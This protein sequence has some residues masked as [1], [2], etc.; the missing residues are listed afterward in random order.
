LVHE[1]GGQ[2]YLDGANLNSMVGRIR[3][4][5]LGVD[6]LH[7]NLH[8]TFSTP[9]GGGGP[10]AGP[11]C[12]KS[13]LAPFL[14]NPRVVQKADASFGLENAEKGINIGTFLGNIP[15]FIRAYA[16]I[17][18]LGEEGLQRASAEAVLNANYLMAK[19]I[20]D[21]D[22][23]CA[24]GELRMHEFV[25]SV[26]G[27]KE[28]TARW[29]TGKVGVGAMDFAK[30]LMDF[31]IHPP[32]VLFPRIK[33][34][35]EET[36]MFEPTQSMRL[37]DLDKV[38]EAMIAIKKEAQE[39]PD[40]VKNAPYETPVTSQTKIARVNVYF[41]AK[42]AILK[43]DDIA[44][45][46]G[47]GE[48]TF[49][50]PQEATGLISYQDP[51]PGWQADKEKCVHIGNTWYRIVEDGKLAV[52]G[53]SE[54]A[55]REG[56][57]L[58]SLEHVNALP[59]VGSIV[60][61]GDE[62]MEF[63]A[64]KTNYGVECP[65]TGKV[66]K[67]NEYVMIEDPSLIK[68][69]PYGKGWLFVVELPSSESSDQPKVLSATVAATGLAVAL[70]IVVTLA[71]Y[72]YFNPAALIQVNEMLVLGGREGIGALAMVPMLGLISTR[73]SKARSFDVERELLF[74]R[75]QIAETN[76]IMGVVAAHNIACQLK[77][78][79]DEK[80][81]A[82]VLWASAPSQHTT[83]DALIRFFKELGIDPTKIICFHMDEYVGLP[84]GAPQSFAKV[85]RE[86]LFTQLGI[87]SKN[88]FYFD[89][90]VGF[91][92]AQKLRNKLANKSTTKKIIK[93]LTQ[94]LEEQIQP[95]IDKILA[96]FQH[97]GGKFDMVVGG[98]GKH[99]H[100]AFNDY[101]DADF[102]DPKI[103]KLV[104]LTDISRE[105]QVIDKEFEK[106][107]DV[108]THALTFTLPPMFDAKAIHIIVPRAFK[109]EAVAKTL[110]K[111]I[112][113]KSPASGLRK[114]SVL[115][116]V[117]F[118]FDRDAAAKS[119]VAQAVLEAKGYARPEAYPLSIPERTTL[120]SDDVSLDS[121]KIRRNPT[122]RG[123]KIL[124]IENR[125]GEAR[126][127]A[128]IPIGK[129]AVENKV[130][131]LTANKS[132]QDMIR[133]I[134]E[135]QPQIIIFPHNLEQEVRSFADKAL[136]NVTQAIILTHYFTPVVKRGTLF[137]GYTK[138]L[139]EKIKRPSIAA[140]VSQIKRLG[141]I[142]A[143]QCAN[144][145]QA[146]LAQMRGVPGF[147]AKFAEIFRTGVIKDGELIIE[148]DVRALS[149]SDI[150]ENAF[151]IVSS[152]HPDDLEIACA[153]YLTFLKERGAFIANI[154]FA[155]EH[156]VY[157]R[158]I[159]IRNDLTPGEKKE[160]K[161]IWRTEE[162]KNAA[163]KLNLD[164][165]RY[166]K[167]GFYDRT[168]EKG[169]RIIDEK[170]RSRVKN[171]FSRYV[172][173]YKAERPGS[174]EFIVF[175]NSLDDTHPDHIAT[176]VLTME[177]LKELSLSEGIT[178]KIRFY[179]SPWPGRASLNAYARRFP[180]SVKSAAK[181]KQLAIQ[182]AENQARSLA[183]VGGEM[184]GEFA[185][186]PPKPALIGGKFAQT[187]FL[188][189]YTP[190]NTAGSKSAPPSNGA[191]GVVPAFGLL[192][193]SAL[194]V[195]TL[196]AAAV[197]VAVVSGIVIY[198]LGR[199]TLFAKPYPRLG[200]VL[201]A[202]IFPLAVV[203]AKYL[204]DPLGIPPVSL[205]VTL[206][207]IS[208]F[209]VHFGLHQKILGLYA[210][211]ANKEHAVSW[212]PWALELSV[213]NKLSPRQKAYI[214][215]RNIFAQGLVPLLV[216]HSF[217]FISPVVSATV[218]ALGIVFQIYVNRKDT[219][220]GTIDSRY[221]FGILLL[222]S[223][224]L[225]AISTAST[226]GTSGF[227]AQLA[228]G[229]TNKGVWLMLF[230]PIIAGVRLLFDRK[231]LH[232]QKLPEMPLA[233]NKLSY[234]TGILTVLVLGIP[235]CAIF[236][237][238]HFFSAGLQVFPFQSIQVSLIF[239]AMSICFTTGWL[240]L[241]GSQR[242]KGFG[243]LQIIP[244]I[245]ASPTL[246]YI[247]SLIIGLACGTPLE[248]RVLTFRAMAVLLV[249]FGAW[250]ASRSNNVTP[251]AAKK[252][253]FPTT[254]KEIFP[255]AEKEIEIR[256]PEGGA[257]VFAR[258]AFVFT[259]KIMSDLNTLIWLV[260]DKEALALR[261][262]EVINLGLQ[263]KDKIKVV[264][265][266]VCSQDVLGQ[267]LVI[268][269]R[270]L[271]DEKA[272]LGTLGESA[273]IPTS[274]AKQIEDLLESDKE[275]QLHIID[276]H[277][278]L[279]NEEVRAK[280]KLIIGEAFLSYIDILEEKAQPYGFESYYPLLKQM[281]RVK[282]GK[283]SDTPGHVNNLFLKFANVGR[284]SHIFDFGSGDGFFDY[285]MALRGVFVDGAEEDKGIFTL[286]FAL[287]AYLMQELFDPHNHDKETLLGLAQV[288]RRVRL[289]NKD[290][291]EA[292]INL[293]NYDVVYLFNPYDNFETNE[294][295]DDF[296]EKLNR[297]LSDAQTGLRDDA[298][299]VVLTLYTG[300]PP[301]LPGLEYVSKTRKIK[302]HRRWKKWIL[303]KYRLKQSVSSVV[304]K[305]KCLT[306]TT[307]DGTQLTINQAVK[308]RAVLGI[309]TDRE[310]TNDQAIT[311]SIIQ[312]LLRHPDDRIRRFVSEARKHLLPIVLLLVLLLLMGMNSV[313]GSGNYLPWIIG[314][315]ILGTV[316]ATKQNRPR[317]SGEPSPITAAPNHKGL[318]GA[319]LAAVIALIILVFAGV[320]YGQ[321]D[322][323]ANPLF[324]ALTNL[325]DFA[326]ALWEASLG[327]KIVV[328]GS[329]AGIA[330]LV[331]RSI[332]RILWATYVSLRMRPLKRALAPVEELNR[333]VAR[334]KRAA[335]KERKESGEDAGAIDIRMLQQESQVAT[336]AKSDEI[337][338]SRLYGMS[339]DREKMEAFRRGF[340]IYLRFS[341]CW[342]G[343]FSKPAREAIDTVLEYLAVVDLSLYLAE[344]E[345]AKAGIWLR[346]L[347]PVV[348]MP[349]H[350]R[351]LNLAAQAIKMTD[352]RK[353]EY[354]FLFNEEKLAAKIKFA[355]DKEKTRLIDIIV[356]EG[357]LAPKES[358]LQ[359]TFVRLAGQAD[360]GA[361]KR[362]EKG[363]GKFLRL[364]VLPLLVRTDMP[365]YPTWPQILYMLGVL[366]VTNEGQLQER[367]SQRWITGAEIFILIATYLQ[368]NS[369]IFKK[370]PELLGRLYAPKVPEVVRQ[371]K[372]Q[373]RRKEI[374]EHCGDMLRRIAQYDREKLVTTLGLVHKS[375]GSKIAP[376]V[377]VKSFLKRIPQSASSSEL[378][379]GLLNLIFVPFASVFPTSSE[380]NTAL[381]AA[382]I[383][384]SVLT[385]ALA[386]TV[387]RSIGDSPRLRQYPA[388]SDGPV[389]RLLRRQSPNAARTVPAGWRYG[390]GSSQIMVALVALA[391]A[392]GVGF[393][394]MAIPYFS[395]RI[396]LLVIISIISAIAVLI[397]GQITVAGGLVE[398][399]KELIDF[400]RDW[401]WVLEKKENI[402]E[403]FEKKLA[404]LQKL[405]SKLSEKK[406]K[407]R[408]KQDRKKQSEAT[409][410]R[411][412]L[413]KILKPALEAEFSRLT[414]A[415]CLE[416]ET[417]RR[418]FMR[419]VRKNI[420]KKHRG[421][422][423]FA[424]R[425]D[426]AV[427]ELI[428]KAGVFIEENKQKEVQEVEALEASEK[429]E[430]KERPG[431]RVIFSN[432][433][434][435]A[436]ASTKKIF[437]AAMQRV[438][439]F[440]QSLIKAYRIRTLD[441]L[442]GRLNRAIKQAVADKIEAILD[443]F[444]QNASR[445]NAADYAS[446]D[447][448]RDA[449]FSLLPEKIRMQDKAIEEA[450][451]AL[452]ERIACLV[453]QALVAIE[454]IDLTIE[455]ISQ[456]PDSLRQEIRDRVPQII[457]QHP[458]IIGKL[459]EIDRVI[460][461]GRQHILT[462]YLHG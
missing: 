452:F 181:S 184:M 255:A 454:D 176:N 386:R 17:R 348:R 352:Q 239:L 48:L 187:L 233:M 378:D 361:R 448:L 436:E 215:G 286:Y 98:I 258:A 80:G 391:V 288:I 376:N 82:V 404:Y 199:D 253:V 356:Y 377:F 35:V 451:V 57:L 399:A 147:K 450:K 330:F 78:I 221:I 125:R 119:K 189:K 449:I 28:F 50:K 261:P 12:V 432:L 60:K 166:L 346:V 274:Y 368:A 264:A 223:G 427:G 174:S 25:I 67:V 296:L 178:F 158:K 297:T 364:A 134:R 265:R 403:R 360:E 369:P 459:A 103:V 445:L 415:G 271:Q 56:A 88:I 417:Y 185:A 393:V 194:S 19:L 165:F 137:V 319:P 202:L 129:L 371:E 29:A 46:L 112:W 220:A 327:L 359:F 460:D 131:Y 136:S 409:Q 127:Y 167:L 304:L 135:Y 381:I 145:A 142:P 140:H 116:H 420:P 278:P 111:R 270:F 247:Y 424:A 400:S 426:K 441:G 329:L 143:A 299:F 308:G 217:L 272:Q 75:I 238:P 383:L 229:F 208:Y 375:S 353:R 146:L 71:L 211:E 200:A 281:A 95:H 196:F 395:E 283:F 126:L 305:D 204:I 440:I 268:T 435:L 59:E 100:V 439:N 351:W 5:D 182:L 175:V 292:E 433:Y 257:S 343:I 9:H 107:E 347:E 177:A 81:Q 301:R 251:A 306:A 392:G 32:T 422:E 85:L 366:G 285:K 13:H 113:I 155:A 197:I 340:P 317:T 219:G 385:L 332:V 342:L 205:I 33:D 411:Q 52:V 231:F 58:E 212:K 203:L 384:G 227:F 380:P 86:R 282:Y 357:D 30:R 462:G 418:A 300:R 69:D 350:A 314:T 120:L 39:N 148:E 320:A 97:F 213:W 235:F 363:L 173:K 42:T 355:A 68:T 64:D 38:A 276:D 252:E 40:F 291:F 11:I 277:A 407:A 398:A 123:Q 170:D 442:E 336:A 169:K 171:E 8:K 138:R 406:R 128:G 338:L 44:A 325:G 334:E 20:D 99:P 21:F 303:Y 117:W 24:P 195:H 207:L 183:E 461:Q 331:I 163:H 316:L 62:C 22:I 234:L 2:V 382:L 322:P 216:Y 160:K 341:R 443:E 428:E 455:D 63:E 193:A 36:L 45:I 275:E 242:H 141:L 401:Q 280:V 311:E 430:K 263:D 49:E 410:E 90:Q 413:F 7:V 192:G 89:S 372:A 437:V 226:A 349:E 180:V 315:L 244:I 429:A 259:Q 408:E 250:I 256:F 198:K 416:L 245:A 337:R 108:P 431:L 302:S 249:F 224:S 93:Q 307:E 153:A 345:G 206:F 328:F 105:Q 54:E 240:L 228:R 326:R 396:G 23:P 149:P 114:P 31:G 118:Y 365:R 122:S 374:Q 298:I 61:E 70:T 172:R 421:V 267:A 34:V 79:I 423:K 246:M 362:A 201:R 188:E 51:V 133:N 41:E 405:L 109:A 419:I 309:I 168:D 151:V 92:T 447:E 444:R 367:I 91:A 457:S 236:N 1:E 26:K 96:E 222:I 150:P 37:E 65:I 121:L 453:Q 254:G 84:A 83:W 15:V 425:I 87:P 77:Q 358:S 106:I 66:A 130:R 397:I 156:R 402:V 310:E 214:I 154:V 27:I 104:H 394:L 243:N 294:G 53:L 230:C 115:P 458:Q 162:I 3:P 273:E 312:Q 279:D 47:M 260:K 434:Q 232:V 16:Y 323:Y 139:W 4:G 388:Q 210:H 237:Q 290:I 6:V 269:E 191:L 412:R 18:A 354:D 321:G 218:A 110:D 74:S 344:D 370:R 456:S 102:N 390:N 55:T 335:L 379:A 339:G 76:E 293:K 14:P 10:G 266:G 159:D 225:L 414:Q 289:Q 262:N 190:T 313:E 333:Q 94:S 295:A 438:S 446:T 179:D 152:P 43:S 72:F 164:A 373:E 73:A 161:I 132:A 318:V 284:D 287:K 157:I 144:R 209:V 324:D 389:R 101:P 124:V 186:K 248:P 241:L 387:L